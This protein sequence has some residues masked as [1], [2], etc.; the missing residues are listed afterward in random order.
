[1]A[2]E[3]QARATWCWLRSASIPTMCR[4][5]LI[6][7]PLWEWG[8]PDDAALRATDLMR[9]HNF[10]WTGK[11]QRIRLDPGDLP[12]AIWQIAPPGDV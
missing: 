6:E 5:R 7:V 3:H 9:G 4:R 8:L 11:Y 10:V 2:S 1:M 12:F